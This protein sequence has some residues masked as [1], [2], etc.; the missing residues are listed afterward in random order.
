MTEACV[1]IATLQFLTQMQLGYL[2]FN[3]WFGASE[4]R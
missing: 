1:L 4:Q 3:K 2:H